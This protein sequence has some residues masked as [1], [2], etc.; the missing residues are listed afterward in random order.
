MLNDMFVNL[1]VYRRRAKEYLDSKQ[2]G[3]FD[4]RLAA[5]MAHIYVPD[6]CDEIQRLRG[7][8]TDMRRSRVVLGKDSIKRVH[9]NELEKDLILEKFI[10]E[11]LVPSKL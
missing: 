3:L 10:D 6:L 4:S 11:N 5:K 7:I 2:H 9:S 1:D 8:I